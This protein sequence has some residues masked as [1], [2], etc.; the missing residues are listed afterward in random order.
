MASQRYKNV[1]KVS[2]IRKLFLSS[3][4][5][6]ITFDS[7]VDKINQKFVNQKVI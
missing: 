2:I 7:T 5:E 3:F 1:F 4:I 6:T